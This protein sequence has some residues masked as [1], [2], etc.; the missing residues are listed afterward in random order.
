MHRPIDGHIIITL[1]K[2]Q[3]YVKDKFEV[4]K[5]RNTQGVQ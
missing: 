1:S 4:E 2:Q 5:K 3:I